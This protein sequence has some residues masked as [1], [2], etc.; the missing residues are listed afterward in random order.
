M[1]AP[2]TPTSSP[3]NSNGSGSTDTGNSSF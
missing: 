3:E 2:E 1:P